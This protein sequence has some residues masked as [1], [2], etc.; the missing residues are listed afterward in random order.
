MT[1]DGI[2]RNHR[3]I[4]WAGKRKTINEVYGQHQAWRGQVRFGGGSHPREEKM[5]EDTST[6]ARSGTLAGQGRSRRTGLINGRE[7]AK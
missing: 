5:R 1:D 2:T 3:I 7:V 4:W 6:E